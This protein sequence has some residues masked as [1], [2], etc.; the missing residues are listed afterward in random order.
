[1]N[2]PHYIPLADLGLTVKVRKMVAQH[3]PDEQVP[4]KEAVLWKALDSQFRYTKA[5]NQWK[6]SI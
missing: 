5:L 4:L 1:M 3:F 6:K 2:N